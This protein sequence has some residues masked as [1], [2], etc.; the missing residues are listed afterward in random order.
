MTLIADTHFNLNVMLQLLRFL[1]DCRER[2][3]SEAVDATVRQPSA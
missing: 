1:G 2:P 3:I